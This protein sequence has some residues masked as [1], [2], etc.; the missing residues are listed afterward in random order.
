MPAVR[1]LARSGWKSS[2]QPEAAIVHES[3]TTPG[4]SAVSGLPSGSSSHWNTCWIHVVVAVAR[5]LK[6]LTAI[7]VASGAIPTEL[8]P[9]S[10]PTITPMVQVPWPLT[11]VGVAG[12]SPFGSY[13][14][15]APPRQR[16]ARSGWVTSTPVSML[17][18]TIPWPRYTRSHSAGALTRATFVSAG[19]DVVVSTAGGAGG[20]GTTR[21]GRISRT[22][23]G[24][25]S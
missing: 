18:T 16:P 6:I 8:P 4:A 20:D 9:A 12:C 2:M 5:S 21:S 3:L 15:L 19:A 1:K 24:A 25:A 22:S 23:A 10:P 14:L 13:Q 17:A 7:H 11:S